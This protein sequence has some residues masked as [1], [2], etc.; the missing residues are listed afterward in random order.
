MMKQ[1]CDDEA[2]CDDD[3]GGKQNKNDLSRESVISMQ[4]LL[5]PMPMPMPM[6]ILDA[7]ADADAALHCIA[8]IQFNSIQ[9]NSIQSR[10]T[11]KF[12]TSFTLHILYITLHIF[13]SFK[14]FILVLVFEYGIRIR[15]R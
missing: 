10:K 7:D 11:W 12:T 6:Q 5:M 14:D 15:I 1:G 13:L 8:L 3:D 2:S 4:I 9:F